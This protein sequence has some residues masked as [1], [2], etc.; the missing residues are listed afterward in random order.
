MG[1]KFKR[2]VQFSALVMIM[3]LGVAACDGEVAELTTT[4]VLV[5]DSDGPIQA[6]TTTV[7]V[8]TE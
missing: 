6:T 1:M 2:S 3:A 4:S 5:T 8:A 7:T